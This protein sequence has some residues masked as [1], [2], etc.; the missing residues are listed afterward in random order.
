MQKGQLVEGGKEAGMCREVME[1]RLSEN[2]QLLKIE[3]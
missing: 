2:D 3:K 1:T